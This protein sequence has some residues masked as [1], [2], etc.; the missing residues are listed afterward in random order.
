[1]KKKMIT[2]VAVALA[3]IASIATTSFAGSPTP[4]PRPTDFIQDVGCYNKY[5]GSYYYDQAYA[6]VHTDG[7]KYNITVGV[8]KNNKPQE[9][10]TTLVRAYT[11]ATC[12][13][14]KLQGSGGYEWVHPK[15]A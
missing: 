10:V 8:W 9:K 4:T 12:Y 13:S 15:K 11:Y 14:G 5:N 2:I 6:K 3:L 7:Y 1:M